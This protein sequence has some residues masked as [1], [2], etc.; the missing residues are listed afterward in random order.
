MSLETPRPRDAFILFG[1][2]LLVLFLIGGPLQQ[3]NRWW[4]L[5]FTEIVIVLGITLFMSRLVR[6]DLRG[7]IPLKKIGIPKI[8][9]ALLLPLPV[10]V[11]SDASFRFVE[12]VLGSYPVPE[13]WA[14]LL[15]HSLGQLFFLS[16]LYGVL[17]ATC[18]EVMHR[19]FILKAFENA[20]TQKKAVI[21]AAVL[22][23]LYHMDP[24][25]IPGAVIMGLVLGYM[26]TES[27]S[28]I[29]AAIT[30]FMYNVLPFC[31]FYVLGKEITEVIILGIPDFLN[32]AVWTLIL[33]ALLYLWRRSGQ[34]LEKVR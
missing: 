20:W 13:H 4:G 23:G 32:V 11:L 7:I 1:A 22:F 27:Q 9:L 2:S 8:L 30:H 18:E 26:V 16:F 28:L 21:A 10:M 19:G 3:W 14:E 12:Y 33:A 25:R 15:P 17:P 6:A 31:I 34:N 29:P 24:W 5:F